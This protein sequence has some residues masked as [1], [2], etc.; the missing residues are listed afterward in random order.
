MLQC[1]AVCPVVIKCIVHPVVIKCMCCSGV[2]Q[3][4]AL[5]RPVSCSVLHFIV[6]FSAECCTLLW[7]FLECVAVC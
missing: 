6:E 5:H 1:V 7:S 2:K 3:S 4:A